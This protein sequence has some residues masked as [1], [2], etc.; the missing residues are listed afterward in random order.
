V[1]IAYLLRPLVC[2]VIDPR[3]AQGLYE[4]DPTFA[5]LRLSECVWIVPGTINPLED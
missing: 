3:L 5:R 4:L 2:G 1:F